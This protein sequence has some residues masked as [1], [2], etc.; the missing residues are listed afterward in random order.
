MTAA[1]K[2]AHDF[3]ALCA[4]VLAYYHGEGKYNF[5]SLNDYDRDNAAFDAWKDIEHRIESA[6]AGTERTDS[7]SD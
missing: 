6:L 4:E 5:R 1:K 2:P 7:S 3:R